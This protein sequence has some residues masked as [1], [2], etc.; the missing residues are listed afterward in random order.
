L[1]VCDDTF[2][3]GLTDG[4]DL[5]NI[6][7]TSNSDSDVEVLESLETKKEDGFEDLHSERLR[8]EELDG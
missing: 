1:V 8:F 6:A 5:G 2:G 7:S 4:I 3:K